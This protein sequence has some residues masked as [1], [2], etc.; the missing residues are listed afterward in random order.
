MTAT[1]RLLVVAV[2]ARCN[3]ASSSSSRQ[4][5][6]TSCRSGGTIYR[7]LEGDDDGKLTRWRG[8]WAGTGLLLV[9]PNT[10]GAGRRSV[11]R[12]MRPLS[13][14]ITWTPGV[15]QAA[16]AWKWLRGGDGLALGVSPAGRRGPWERSTELRRP[17][18]PDSE[19]TRCTGDRVFRDRG[20]APPSSVSVQLVNGSTLGG[21]TPR[22]DVR[23]RRGLVWNNLPAPHPADDLRRIYQRECW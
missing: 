8:H 1:T 3:I 14:S 5:T 4:P 6:A 13:A 21:G 20:S 12:N 10:T 15:G 18:A 11:A 22:Y 9:Q 7:L 23:S 17:P 2:S 19:Q 16:F